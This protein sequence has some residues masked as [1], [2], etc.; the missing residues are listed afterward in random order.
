MLVVWEADQS[1][2]MGRQMKSKQFG[3][4]QHLK[5][6]EICQE[7]DITWNVAVVG[8]EQD[9][10]TPAFGVVLSAETMVRVPNHAQVLCDRVRRRN[11]SLS[12]SS[13]RNSDTTGS[14][15]RREEKAVL[16]RP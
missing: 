13:D 9:L 8:H 12:A 6:V 4:R 16:T 2:S 1:S 7:G 15:P 14:N 10:V 11:N 3:I 5:P